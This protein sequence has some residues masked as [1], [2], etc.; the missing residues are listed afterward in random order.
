MRGEQYTQPSLNSQTA[1]QSS[2]EAQTD[3]PLDT[4]PTGTQ[5]RSGHP[6]CQEK[7]FW[8]PAIGRVRYI[9]SHQDGNEMHGRFPTW[10]HIWQDSLPGEAELS[11]RHDS[12]PCIFQRLIEV[13][14]REEC[15]PEQRTIETIE[16]VKS[17]VSF[18]YNLIFV[19]GARH[20]PEQTNLRQ[21]SSY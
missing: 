8:L 21:V 13:H 10:E 9:S 2:R 20:R 11:R 6:R 17:F 12:R 16:T 4:P 5:G 14:H 18:G 1:V 15:A 3:S 19:S 7:R